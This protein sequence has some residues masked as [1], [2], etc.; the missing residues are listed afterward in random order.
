MSATTKERNVPVGYIGL[1]NMGGALA[2][3]LQLQHPLW[4]H[5]LNESAMQRL[6]DLG[7]TPCPDPGAVADECDIIFLCLPTTGH[8]RE[9]IFG[10]GGLGERLRSGT[11]VVDQTTGDPHATRYIA[12]LLAERDVDL[13]DAPVS[14]GAAGARAGTIAIMVGATQGQYDR[15][16][17]LLSTISPNVFHAGTV[18][19]GQVIKLVNN[20][21]S[22]AQRLLT[23]EAIAL[24]A[25]NG[26]DPHRAVDILIAGGGRN[27][28]LER[29]MGPRVLDGK[30]SPGFTLGLLH[31]DIKLACELG[32]ESGTPMFFA[33]LTRELYQMHV[34]E[35]GYNAQVD[36]AALVVDRLA[37]THVVPDE[38]DH[39]P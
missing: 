22:G 28:Y 17:P 34:N 5:D 3:R 13:V 9:A 35:L 30:L 20:L 11:T 33:A 18:G 29:F 16:Q 31:K 4:V 27:S 37:G 15:V 2:E 24:A 6:A 23:L 10:S 8:V 12:N 14:G 26:L 36:A 32:A 25:K 7:A 39:R 21:L 38:H 19:S 1:G